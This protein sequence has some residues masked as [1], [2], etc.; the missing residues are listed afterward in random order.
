[1]CQEEGSF[2]RCIAIVLLL[3]SDSGTDLPSLA[4]VTFGFS[5]FHIINRFLRKELAWKAGDLLFTY[6]NLASS[7]TPDDTFA[8]LFKV[9]LP[10]RLIAYR[11]CFSVAICVGRRSDSLLWDSY[12]EQGS[13]EEDSRPKSNATG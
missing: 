3:Q 6:I 7:P 1:M 9:H 5:R 2:E 11:G 12:M 8:N 13:T 10:R 4:T